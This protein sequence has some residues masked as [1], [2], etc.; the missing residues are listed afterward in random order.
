MI[1]ALVV[2]VVCFVQVIFS[3]LSA[4]TGLVMATRLDDPLVVLFSLNGM[5]DE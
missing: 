1:E 5:L 3:W 2:W 4:R